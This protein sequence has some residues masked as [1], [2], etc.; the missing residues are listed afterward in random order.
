[1]NANGL[2]ANVRKYNVGLLNKNRSIGAASCF[3]TSSYKIFVRL[4]KKKKKKQAI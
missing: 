4:T 1:M 3:R 2:F